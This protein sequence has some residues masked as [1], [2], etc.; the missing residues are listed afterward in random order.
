MRRWMIFAAAL[1]VV[2][3][4]FVSIATAQTLAGAL[5]GTVHDSQGASFPAW[6]S[7]SRHRH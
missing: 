2:V 3:T 4:T 1:C 5:I 7:A 6:K